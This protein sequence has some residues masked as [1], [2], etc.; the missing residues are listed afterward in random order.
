MIEYLIVFSIAILLAWGA[1]RFKDIK[2]IV[3][4]CLSLLI[5]I[6]ALFAGVRNIGVGTDTLVYSDEY[7][8]AGKELKGWSDILTFD[9]NKFRN[10]SYVLL[11]YGAS[12]LSNNVWIALFFTE[13]AILVPLYLSIYKYSHTISVKYVVFTILYLFTFYNFSF[14][15]MR[16]SCAVSFVFWAFCFYKEQT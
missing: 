16:Q 2:S 14:N 15:I 1:D 8:N 13:L 7:F 3:F 9:S 5:L 11:N 10:K 4:F 12:Y 6:L